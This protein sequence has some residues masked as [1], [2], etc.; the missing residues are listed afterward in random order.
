MKTRKGFTLIELLAVII[1]IGILALITVP[2]VSN[3]INDSRQKTYKAHE[4][5]M[6]EAAKSLTVECINGTEACDLPKEGNSTDIYLNELIDKSFSQRLQNPQGNGYCN[7]NLSYVTVSR[8]SGDDFEYSACLYCGNYT[9][10]GTCSPVEANNDTEAPTCGAIEGQSSEWTRESR[11]ISVGCNDSGSGCTRNRF[12]KTFKET[13]TDGE[14]L[15]SDR[16]GNTKKCP[17]NVKVDKTAPTCELEIVGGAEETNGWLSGPIKVKFKD[18]SRHDAESGIS[19]WGIGTSSEHP[20]YNRQELIDLTNINGV[21]TVFGYVKDNA[22]NEGTCSKNL[23]AGVQRPDFDIYYG[24]QIFPLKENYSVSNIT[25][26]NDKVLK[27]TSTNPTMTFTGMSKYANATR[28]VITTDNVVTNP[29]TYTLTVGSITVRPRPMNS[30]TRLEFDFTK[31]SYNTYIFKMGV[32]NNITNTINRIEIQQTKNDLPT[33]KNVNVNLHPV[34]SREKVKTNGFSFDDGSHFQTDYFKSFVVTNGEVNGVAQTKNDIPMYSDKKVYRIT[35]GDNTSPTIDVS[36]SPDSWTNQNVTLTGKGKDSASGIVA[37][38]FNKSSALPY[39]SSLWQ[40]I[41]LTKSEITKTGTA[42]TN[43]TYYFN[44]KDEAGN[45]SNKSIVV[46][47]IDKI[48]PVCDVT[49]NSTINC[50]DSGDDDNGVSSIG[51]YIYGKDAT[52]SSTCNEVTATNNLSVDYAVNAIGTWKLYAKDRA[53]NISDVKSYTYYKVTYDK[54]SGSNCTKSDAIVR[55]GQ[56]IDLTPTCTRKGY[57]FKGWSLNGTKITSHNIASN[58]TIKAIWEAN[59]YNIEYEYNEGTAPSS[60]VPDS[61]TY[62]VGATINGRPTKD[63]YTFNGWSDNASLTS[64]AFSK[65][66]GTDETDT[67]KFYAKWCRNC[68]SVSHG[69]CTLTATTAGTCTYETSCNTGYTISG[70]GTYN[71]TCTANDYTI[72]YKANGGSGNDQTQSVKYDA[73]WQTKGSIFTRNGYI[74]DGWATSATGG[75][76]YGI[77]ATQSAYKA[78]P[79]TLYAHWKPQQFTIYYHPNGGS[80]GIVTNTLIYGTNWSTEGAIFTKTGSSMDGWSTSASGSVTH[81][82]SKAQG[83]FSGNADLHLYAH[84]KKTPYTI[85]YTANG[86]SG[87]NQTQTVYYNTSFTT[88]GKIFS[89]TDYNLIGWYQRL[90]EYNYVDCMYS[91]SYSGNSNYS[92]PGHYSIK[93]NKAYTPQEAK[94]LCEKSDSISAF[95][96]TSSYKVFADLIEHQV[97]HNTSCNCAEDLNTFT[98]T[99]A[100][101]SSCRQK[102]GKN[103]IPDFSAKCHCSGNAYQGLPCTPKTLTSGTGLANQSAC[104]NICNQQ[105]HCSSGSLVGTCTCKQPVACIAGEISANDESTC[106]TQCKNRNCKY[107]FTGESFSSSNIVVQLEHAYPSKRYEIKE[108][109]LS[110]NYNFENTANVTLYADWQEKAT[111]PYGTT[112]V[113]GAGTDNPTCCANCTSVAHGSCS[114]ELGPNNTCKYNTSCDSGYTLVAGAG[115]NSPVCCPSCPDMGGHGTC[116]V[117]LENSTCKYATSCNP[118]YK[119]S[120]NGTVNA[121]CT[122]CPGWLLTNPGPSVLGSIEKAQGQEWAFMTSSDKRLK[123]GWAWVSGDIY[124]N[125][126]T[127]D[128]NQNGVCDTGST[129]SEGWFYLNPDGIMKK[130]WVCD[131][132]YW[133][134][135]WTGLATGLNRDYPEGELSGRMV[136]NS[137]NMDLNGTKYSFDKDGHCTQNCGWACTDEYK[138]TKN[139]INY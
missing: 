57:A 119:L 35:S 88:K 116:T 6:I 133:Y 4:T 18:S 89:R 122:R 94:I 48:K 80:G 70:N 50:T 96:A 104:R 85:T 108:Y 62:G 127:T 27:T 118:G 37:F 103:L 111:C 107:T 41:S 74:M 55:S 129:N 20:N 72:T 58:I 44:L 75:I 102:C 131:G 40:T 138:V 139:I 2:I 21:V 31:G 52:T 77:S 128:S 1:I 117:S 34:L 95:K 13:A 81:N 29:T 60:G 86:G 22:G 92:Y 7:E 8:V 12:T 56:G 28:V 11:V 66:I 120:N 14:I 39:V 3:Y 67:K 98:V 106:S 69:S 99:T 33:N 9:S 63:S 53:G 136:A 78:T 10:E 125:Q 90:T 54:N 130:G 76:A 5:T 24:Y 36:K 91:I 84:W 49:G 113:A 134:Y 110:T 79:T 71:P 126:I 93:V 59:V 123:N 114:L 23:R 45:I 73:T 112:M 132:T 61:Y 26:T 17:V 38:G 47:N 137:T 101:F 15:I 83:S 87:S 109:N 97:S 30:N 32:E 121:T 43:G 135:L 64:P 100:D 65:T 19:T 115:T 51:C 124:S 25:V 105:F 16:A 82:L 68:A 46:D 42:E